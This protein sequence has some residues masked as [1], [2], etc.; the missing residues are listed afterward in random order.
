MDNGQ[1][2]MDAFEGFSEAHGETKISQERRQGKQAANSYIKRTPL[3]L[4]LINGHLDGGLGVGSIPIN[5]NNMCKFGAL[6]IDTYP[7]DHVALDKKLLNLKIPCVVCRSKSG[8]AHIFFFLSDWMSAG[9]FRDKASEIASVIGFGNCE[10]FPKQEQILVERGDVGNFINLPYHNK[11]QTMRY[12]FK[13]DGEMATFEEF[14]DLVDE[15]KVKPNDFFKLQVGTKKTEPF[16]ESPPC[17]NVM[18]LNGIGEGARNMSLFNYGAMFKKMDPDNWKALLEKF[19]IDYCSSPLS[20]QEI[21][22]IQGQLDKKEY[23]Y[24]CNQEPLKSHCNKTLCKRR[25]YGIG[26][27]VDA[28]EITG[29]SIVKSEPRVFFADLDGRR[30]ELTSFDLQSQSKFQIACLEQQNFMPP[31]VRESDWQVLI[32]GLLAEANEIE[33][34]EELTYKGHFNQLLESFCYGRVQAQSAEE[35]LIGKPWIMEGLVY[36]KI[37]SFIEFLRQKGFTHYSK[38]QIQERIKEI[39]N[40]DKCSNVRNFKTTEGK[41]KSIRV[42]WVPEVREDVEIPK[43][44]FEEEVPF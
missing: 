12:A 32:N 31:K 8:G 43:V 4:E 6:D 3:T 37:D 9:E 5:E 40:G 18:A 29:I 34:P 15:R 38:G 17:L 39:N 23:F 28:V 19:N 22:H 42:W 26:A 20:A 7:I 27:N 21:V 44:E 2:F 41:F 11:E 16:P 36:F 1:R 24:T 25:K 14:L 33:V 13:K 10:I 30:L 35:L